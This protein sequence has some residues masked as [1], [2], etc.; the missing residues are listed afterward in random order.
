MRQPVLATALVFVRRFYYKVDIRQSNP[1]QVLSTAFY[2]ACKV[3]ECPQH[4]RV[5]VSEARQLWQGIQRRIT[6]QTNPWALTEPKDFVSSDTSKLG[7]CEFW[8]ISELDAQL[9]VHHPYRSL[10][11][12]ETVLSLT[13]DEAALSWS[14]I[15]DHYLTDLPL[16]HAPHMVATAAVVLAVVIRPSQGSS[17]NQPAAL[18]S[19]K[20]A[21]LAGQGGVKAASTVAGQSKAQVLAAWLARSNLDVEALIDSVQEMMSLYVVWEQYSEKT[22][23]EQIGRCVRARGLD[24]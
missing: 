17:H 24:K 20:L 4:I 3:E 7:E 5:I 12:L 13:A 22:C 1:Y 21:Q 18:V 19:A 16:I 2:L 6:V 23:R 10:R 15:N 11:E 8:L 14:I 9:I